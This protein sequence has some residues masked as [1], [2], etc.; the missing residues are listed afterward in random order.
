MKTAREALDFR[1]ATH[2]NLLRQ[3][4]VEVCRIYNEIID[5]KGP[6]RPDTLDGVLHVLEVLQADPDPV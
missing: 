3:V 6:M 2:I 1:I 5:N 4:N